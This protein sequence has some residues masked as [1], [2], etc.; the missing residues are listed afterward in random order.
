MTRAGEDVRWVDPT[1]LHPF[2]L[3]GTVVDVPA[4]MVFVQ[5]AL[6]SRPGPSPL[7]ALMAGGCRQLY[8]PPPLVHVGFPNIY[9]H[10][11]RTH[12]IN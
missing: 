2:A 8:C 6:L 7:H 1:R 12:T 4:S 9:G 3:V 10:P 11:I 5:A